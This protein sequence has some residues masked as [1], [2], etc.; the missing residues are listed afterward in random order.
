MLSAEPKWLFW[1]WQE[2]SLLLLSP[3]FSF[4]RGSFYVDKSWLQRPQTCIISLNIFLI[5]KDLKSLSHERTCFIA[6][7][8][9]NY[10][11]ILR[12]FLHTGVCMCLYMHVSNTKI[13]T[14]ICTHKSHPN[15]RFIFEKEEIRDNISVIAIS[16]RIFLTNL[17]R[18][19]FK[20]KVK[21]IKYKLGPKCNHRSDITACIL[22]NYLITVRIVLISNNI[23]WG[24]YVHW[25]HVQ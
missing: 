1:A 3:F 19:L 22:Q 15:W 5:S 6:F 7:T 20:N 16:F 21:G 24:S 23:S 10:R 17:F 8:A 11:V 18:L 4:E 12:K 14:C 9:W 13:Q 2:C 25:S